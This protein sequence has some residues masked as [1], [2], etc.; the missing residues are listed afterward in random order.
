MADQPT[1]RESAIDRINKTFGPRIRT[2]L[3]EI[4]ESE[5]GISD[6]AHRRALTQINDE[7][8]REIDA[9]PD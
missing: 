8:V 4:G 5:G 1:L 9:L 3:A 2:L 6:E 7:I